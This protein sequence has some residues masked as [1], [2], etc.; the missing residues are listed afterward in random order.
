MNRPSQSLI[1]LNLSEFDE[2]QRAELE[3]ALQSENLQ[4]LLHLH[5]GNYD[6]ILKIL[7]SFSTLSKMPR[8]KWLCQ[9]QW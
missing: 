8:N 4:W 2:H 9:E 1:R 5:V 7:T 3:E 6:G